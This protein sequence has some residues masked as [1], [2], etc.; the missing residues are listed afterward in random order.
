MVVMEQLLLGATIIV[1]TMV[2]A[3]LFWWGI[4]AIGIWA[5]KQ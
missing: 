3:L 4:A 5:A 1:G 2:L